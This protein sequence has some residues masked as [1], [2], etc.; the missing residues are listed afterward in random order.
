MNMSEFT[1]N[2]INHI[3]KF[4][5]KWCGE[6]SPETNKS[7]FV[8]NIETREETIG[9]NWQKDKLVLLP[10]SLTIL[11]EIDKSLIMLPLREITKIS[12]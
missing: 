10:G 11:T 1:I 9:F 4:I 7:E 8:V 12:Y 5:E 3:W 6:L 2:D